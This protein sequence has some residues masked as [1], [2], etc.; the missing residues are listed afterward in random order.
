MGWVL[1]STRTAEN[2]KKS[3]GDRTTPIGT[4]LP[5]ILVQPLAE[6]HSSKFWII[7]GSQTT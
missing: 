7:D 5:G 6:A 3:L 2:G 1:P 4:L